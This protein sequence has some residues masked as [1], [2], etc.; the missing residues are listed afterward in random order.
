MLNWSNATI[1]CGI[2]L[3]EYCFIGAGSVINK[4]VKPFAVGWQSI[5]QIGW[6]GTTGEKID[7]PLSNEEF[8]CQKTGEKYL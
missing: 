1:V 5:E 2:T 6:M 4:D 7:L 3:G 8:V